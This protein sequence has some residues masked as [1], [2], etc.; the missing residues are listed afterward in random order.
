M[1]KGS[2]KAGYGMEKLLVSGCLLG[3]ACRYDGRANRNE[4]VCALKESWDV[5]PVCPEALGG[6]KAPREPAEQRIIDGSRRV[7]SRDGKDVTEFFEKGAQRVLELARENQCRFAVL[8]ENSPS[9]G[10]GC[11]YDGTFTGRK[12][13]GVGVTAGLLQDH[14]ITVAGENSLEKLTEKSK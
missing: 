9:C 11:I 3:I 12:I 14:G 13:P 8:K 4:A 7:V 1:E 2:K 5:I 10:C 6:M